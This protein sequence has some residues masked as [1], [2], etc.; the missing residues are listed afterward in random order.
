MN[1]T[2]SLRASDH[3]LELHDAS[4]ALDAMALGLP[5]CVFEETDLHPE[6]FELRNGIAGEIMQKFV[7]Y[8][9]RVAFVVK[10]DH[11]YG[12]RLDELMVDHR[13]HPVI[14][15]FPDINAAERWLAD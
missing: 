11:P 9:F 8:G 15:F 5:G 6:F 3:N 1:D 12:P 10:P 7:N 13:S 14:R 4:N 2:A